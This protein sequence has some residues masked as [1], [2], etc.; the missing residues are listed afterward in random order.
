MAIFT[1]EDSA[2]PLWKKIVET[3]IAASPITPTPASSYVCATTPLG[4]P[5]K[6]QGLALSDGMQS[7][8]QVDWNEIRQEFGCSSAYITDKDCSNF[9]IAS[10]IYFRIKGM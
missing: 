8:L 3:L 6:D 10:D 5:Q 1:D 2:S 4:K 7:A 9:S